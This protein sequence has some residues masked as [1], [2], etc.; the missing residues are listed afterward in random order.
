MPSV[1]LSDIHVIDCSSVPGWTRVARVLRVATEP[2]FPSVV[3]VHILIIFFLDFEFW[4]I[5]ES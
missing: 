1:H 2:T 5:A 3:I 4:L